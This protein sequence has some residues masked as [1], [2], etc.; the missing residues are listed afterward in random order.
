MELE[1]QVKDSVII[2]ALTTLIEVN[3]VALETS[4]DPE[5]IEYKTFLNDASRIIINELTSSVLN[6]D[7]KIGKPKWS[8]KEI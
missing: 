1:K 3:N 6:P 7:N 5:E 4:K 8:T 2:L